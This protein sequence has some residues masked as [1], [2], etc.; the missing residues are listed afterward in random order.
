LKFIVEDTQ[1][2]VLLVQDRLIEDRGPKIEDRYPLFLRHG[3]GQASILDPRI[4]L[5]SLD[6]D[7]PMIERESREN[8]KNEVTAENLAYVIYT[9]GSTG[10]P[11]GAA[12]NHRS[13]VNAALGWQDAY[14]LR[15]ATTCHLQM[16]NFSFDVFTADWVRSLCF[17]GKLV[18]C[19]QELLLFPGK[20]YELMRQHRID[21]AEFVPVVL[22]ELIKYLNETGQ[23][24]HFMRLLIVGSDN[25][26]V[27]EHRELHGLAGP[28]CRVVNSYGMTEATIDSLY[29]EGIVTDSAE[30]AVVPLGRPFPNAQSYILDSSLEPV[31]IGVAGELYLGGPSL[32]RGYFNRPDLTAERFIPDL[33]SGEDGAR[34]YK[35][36]DRARYLSDG[37]IEF[38]GRVDR[39]AK[40]RGIRLELGEIEMALKQHPDVRDCA[41][42]ARA[43][44]SGGAS[45]VAYVVSG[46][47]PNH[48]VT[49][50]RSFLQQKLPEYMVPSVFV[51]LAALPLSPNRKVDRRALPEPDLQNLNADRVSI[52]P[53]TPVEQ[54]L[55]EIW[56]KA[57]QLEQIGIHDNFFEVGGHSL[58]ASQVISRIRETFQTDL[59]LRAVFSAPT[60]AGLAERVEAALRAGQGLK[61]LP[62]LN[63]SSRDGSL[64]LSFAQQRLWFL[65]QFDPGSPVYIIPFAVQLAGPLDLTALERSFNE[66]VGRHES[67]RTTFPIIDGNPEQF[68]ASTLNFVLAVRNLQD[69]SEAE[70][71]LTVNRLASE[72]AIRPFDLAEGPLFRAT[73]LRFHDDDHVLLFNMHHIVSDG[74]S[75][76]VLFRELSAL[77]KA[78]SE[79]QSSPLHDLRI[80]YADYTLWQ[81]EWLQGDALKQQLAYW[82]Q[83]LAGAPALLELPTDRPRPRIQSF[84]GARLPLILT[85]SLAQGLKALSNSEGVTLF[86]TLLATF[87]VLLSRYTGQSD[88]VL[89]VPIAGR[90]H[91]DTEELI[92]LFINTL[93]LRSDLSG[94]PTFRTLL[95]R[96][97]DVALGAYAHQD[98][99]FEKL[100]EGLQPERDLSYNPLF[101]VFFALHNFSPTLLTLPGITTTPLDVHNG[102]ARF[103]LALDLVETPDGLTGTLEYNRDLFDAATITRMAGHF[104]TLL[105]AIVANPEQPISDLPILTGPE[106]HQLLFA[107]NE[108][109]RDYPA[110]KCV[111][112]LFEAQVERALDAVAVIYEDKELTY[113]ELNRRANQLAHYLKKLG[114]GPEVLV[115]MLIERSP[116]MFVGLLGVL[117]AGGVYLPLDPEYPEERLAFMLEDAQ[118]AV[119]V[120]EKR[121]LEKLVEDRRSRIEDRDSRFLRPCSG[122][123]SI[124][125]PGLKVVCLD[126]DW[127]DIERESDKN[128]EGEVTPENLAYVIYTSGSTGRPKGV[129]GLHRGLLNR[130]SWMWERYPFES[131]EVCCQKTSLNFVDS[132]WELLGPLVQGIRTVIIADRIVRDPYLLIQTLAA[133]NVSR[134][135]LVPSLLAILLET[136]R[137]LDV[138]L[139]HLKL[140]IASGEPL[141]ED[142][143]KSFADLMPNGKLLNLYGSSEISADV[144]CYDTSRGVAGPAVSIGRPIANTSVYLLGAG[145]QPVP[146]GVAGQLYVGGDGLA[147]GYLNRPELTAEKFVPNPFS[148][149]PGDLLYN[150]G[151]LAYYRPDGNIEFLGRM[152]RQVKIRGFRIELDEIESAL[153]RHPAVRGAVVVVH[154]SVYGDPAS[155]ILLKRAEG[156][157]KTARIVAYIVPNG[158]E[159]CGTSEMRN[160]LKQ[161]LPDYMVPSVF[162]IVEGFPL[163]PNGKVDR[164]ALPAPDGGQHVPNEHYQAPQTP[165]Q[166]LLATIWAE[167][168]NVKKVGIQD[169]FFDLG[170]HSLLATLVVARIRR[171]LATELP[172]RLIFEAPTIEAFAAM[173][174]AKQAKSMRQGNLEPLL[175]QLETMSDEEAVQQLIEDSK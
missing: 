95:R 167:V 14:S 58:K 174:I 42:L 31:P 27:K 30:S 116:E 148:A 10:E 2:A 77:Y 24:L 120:T 142:L 54:A 164:K 101:Q 86:M 47:K 140:C 119:L 175:C 71:Q 134:I 93:V 172:V 147:R 26:Y 41:V 129:L 150:T 158:E 163:T 51:R 124:L 99:P 169:N 76:A 3:S 145:G 89:G 121:L 59:S 153:G 91:A 79:G 56:A 70:R 6:I 96:V 126:G 132:L 49:D 44:V 117:K 69:T 156:I 135:V 166:A 68:V 104:Q 57:L 75:M 113:R 45:L 7:W 139:P 15:R 23:D 137:D 36:G 63:P 72:E 155:E 92:G 39:Q 146:I 131:A 90:S 105:E 80:Q 34:L 125:D 154:D 43:D 88:I 61:I 11:K 46:R 85:K 28:Q 38:L 22:R 32:A 151:D 102:V 159:N 87:K 20:L 5:V 152:D 9:S 62:A 112:E 17:G 83:Q 109:Y 84:R 168:L 143:V 48:A 52:A 74:W 35:T 123:A 160:F 60:V 97:K 149:K 103:D 64:P 127:K 162:V 16:A 110:D 161:K 118:A 100:V 55:V 114:V 165:T 50:L 25:W 98:L 94:N 157:T 19:P 65:D 144:T 130:I 1:A 21:T 33:F 73:L 136:Q 4:R 53:R 37:N 66:L 8:P 13:L 170:G 115:A 171:S 40:I 108:T 128:P 107:W 173:M 18:L 111:H 106:K 12:I 82:K 141:R 133:H 78:F 138:Q 29:F 122:Q 67:L 81:R